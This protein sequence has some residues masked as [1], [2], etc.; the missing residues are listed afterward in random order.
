MSRTKIPISPS[1]GSRTC[2]RTRGDPCVEH[3][4]H[5]GVT[6]SCGSDS[7]LQGSSFGLLIS[8]R[9]R[10]CAEPQGAPSVSLQP[11]GVT[12]APRRETEPLPLGTRGFCWAWCCPRQRWHLCFVLFAVPC[13]ALGSLTSSHTW[14]GFISS[15]LPQIGFAEVVLTQDHGVM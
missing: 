5:S 7:K 8:R 13:L 14:N 3:V 10:R 15:F 11:P 12:G 9:Q 1:F 4:L 2:E 6:D